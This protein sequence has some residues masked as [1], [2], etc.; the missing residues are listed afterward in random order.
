MKLVFY[1]IILFSII[2]IS[3]CQDKFDINQFNDVS[4]DGNLSG[5]TVYVQISPVW[6]G[7]NKPQD[8]LVGKEPFLYVADTE[9]DR[10]VM[11]NLDGKILG[12]KSIKRPVAI[13]Q[14]YKLNLIV[15]AQFDT[16]VNS[17]TKT[18]SAVYKIDLVSAGHQ[19]QNAPVKRLLPRAVDFNSPLREYTAVGAFFDNSFYVG[20]KG[21]NNSSIFDPDNSI[22]IFH[23]KKWYSGQEGDTLIGRV[24]NID[25]LSSG[26]V[27]ANQI[28]S[29]TTFNKR[30]IDM[31]ITLTGNNSFKAQWLTYFVSPIDERYISEFSPYDGTEF[32]R[33]NRFDRPEGS[34][35][36]EAGNIYIADAGKDSIFKFNPFGDELQSF[37]GSKIFNQPYAVAVFDKTLYVADTGNDRILRFIL[38]TD[39]R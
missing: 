12:T 4:T 35:L 17:E 2:V 9:N 36:D 38:S 6:S 14:D 16:I 15:C 28:S 33:P 31:I 22:L 11:L 19:I 37:G 29:L 34:A 5:D 25:P 23:P 26:L 10:I 8:I 1:L 3:G 20:R 7:F 39:L 24:P 18:F 32:A 13:A 21:P 30:N 27:S